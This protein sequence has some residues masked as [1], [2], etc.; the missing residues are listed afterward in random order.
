VCRGLRVR[1]VQGYGGYFGEE[2]GY[3][4]HVRHT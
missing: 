3:S 1:R 2:I 4:G